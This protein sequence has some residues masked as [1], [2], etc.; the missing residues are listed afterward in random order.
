LLARADAPADRVFEPVSER[1]GDA[2]HRVIWSADCGRPYRRLPELARH[3]DQNPEL[4]PAAHN[5]AVADI[6]AALAGK[7]A[8]PGYIPSRKQPGRFVLQTS[9]QYLFVSGNGSAQIQ[10]V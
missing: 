6:A 3:S 9:G 7:P 5:L 1:E 8:L 4:P 10:V 2:A